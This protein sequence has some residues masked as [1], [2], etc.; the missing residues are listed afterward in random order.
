MTDMLA[1]LKPM[2]VYN[3]MLPQLSSAL[4]GKLVE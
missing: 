4:S 2:L 1:L 3:D